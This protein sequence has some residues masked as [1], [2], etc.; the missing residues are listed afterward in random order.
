MEAVHLTVGKNV[1]T[2][3]EDMVVDNNVHSLK[4]KPEYVLSERAKSLGPIETVHVETEEDHV[5]DDRDRNDG[6]QRG[7]KKR[8]RVGRGQ[9]K[10]RPRDARQDASQKICMAVLRNA[11]CP[12]GDSCRFS[13]DLNE[14]MKTRPADI[15]ALKETTGGTCPNHQNNSYCI[16]GAM[17]RIGSGHITKL[18]ENVC[19]ESITSLEGNNNSDQVLDFTTGNILP[20]DVQTQ[21]RKNKYPFQCKRHSEVN[22]K[23]K[24]E[25]SSSSVDVK[26]EDSVVSGRKTCA[27]MTVKKDNA[28]DSNKNVPD[29]EKTE[30]E[31]NVDN[32]VDIESSKNCVEKLKQND[33]AVSR[34]K[35]PAEASSNE[36]NNNASVEDPQESD[37]KT[38]ARNPPTI[39][40]V[41]SSANSFTPLDNLRIKKIVDFS[42]KVVR[43]VTLHYVVTLRYNDFV[44]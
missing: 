22:N 25:A 1:E 37:K 13:H 15:E 16:Y 39:Q 44:E 23:S 35:N 43:Y 4:I 8:R 5:I 34:E 7:R 19:N 12:Y 36:G 3:L 2:K 10:K 6:G 32:D 30:K 31:D 29:I 38:D 26:E 40:T 11:P 17:C 20:R 28:V 18:G 41:I 27:S 9:T 21:L 14:Y 33:D 42:N 24:K